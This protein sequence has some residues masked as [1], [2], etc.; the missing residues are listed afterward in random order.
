MPCRKV[1]RLSIESPFGRAGRADGRGVRRAGA[2]ADT[3]TA[4]TLKAGIRET[5]SRAA[6]VSELA[7]EAP[8]QWNG[9]NTVSGRIPV[10]NRAR[11]TAFPR[12]VLRYTRSPSRTP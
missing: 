9:A 4:H 3:A 11:N 2:V 8:P 5:G 6:T 7:R 12:R 1:G 10:V